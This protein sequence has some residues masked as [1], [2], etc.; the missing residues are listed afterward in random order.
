MMFHTSEYNSYYPLCTCVKYKKEQVRELKEKI[1]CNCINGKR[2]LAFLYAYLCSTNINCRGFCDKITI[3]N[4]YKNKCARNKIKFT[5]IVLSDCAR[6]ILDSGEI[7]LDYESSPVV[8]TVAY[9]IQKEYFITNF[10]M[11]PSKLEMNK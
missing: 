10:H 4:Y 8:N 5:P 9:E 6:Y 3:D 1:P 7:Y 11:E 2:Y